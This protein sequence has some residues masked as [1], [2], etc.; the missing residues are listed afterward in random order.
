MGPEVGR[1][2]RAAAQDLARLDRR[3]GEA[4]SLL[5]PQKEAGKPSSY[6]VAMVKWLRVSA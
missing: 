1:A 2:G 6:L 4:M 5:A 3:A